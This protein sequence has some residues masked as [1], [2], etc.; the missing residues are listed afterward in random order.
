MRISAKSAFEFRR[1]HET[2]RTD[3]S[4]R[5]RLPEHDLEKDKRLFV[6]NPVYKSPSCSYTCVTSSSFDTVL[7]NLFININQLD[8]LNFII[9]L[10]QASTCFE[11]MCWS[12]GG[13]NC[14]YTYRCDDTRDCI[15]QFCPPDDEHMCSKHVGVWNKLIIKLSESSWLIL[16]NKYI[17][18]HGQQNIKKKKSVNKVA[19][20]SVNERNLGFTFVTIKCYWAN[21]PPP[22]GMRTLSVTAA[23]NDC[24]YSG[25]QQFQRF[26]CLSEYFFRR[27]PLCPVSQNL[28][29]KISTLVER[30]LH[31]L[32]EFQYY[33][34]IS[35]SV[36]QNMFSLK[37]SNPFFLRAWY[38]VSFTDDG[39][40]M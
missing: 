34:F 40:K 12:S 11:H 26:W 22:T 20:R 14:I 21:S 29:A 7:I 9:S 5:R 32:S 15:I 36:R 13:Q 28:S 35:P 33:A 39:L 23:V 27:Q 3:V 16:I 1:W 8:A 31:G 24:S 19:Y 30:Q 37:Y 17:E 6:T 38:T 4:C 10:F 25:R 2:I 18:M